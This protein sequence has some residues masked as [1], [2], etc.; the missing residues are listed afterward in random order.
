MQFYFKLPSAIAFKKFLVYFLFFGNILFV[1]YIWLLNS[2]YYITT[3]APGNLYTAIGRITGLWAEIFLLTELILVGRVRWFE[4]LFGF[5]RLNM[6]HR[7]IG[8]GL[9]SL[10]LAHPFFLILGYSQAN[11]VSFLSQFYDF[12]ANK[13]YV[14]YSFMAL[15]IFIYIVFLAVFARKKVHYEVWYFTHLLTY[16]AVGLALWH[17]LGTGDLIGGWTLNYW[18]ILNFSVFGIILAYRFA[19][20]LIRS[21]YHGFTI[22][23][24]IMETPDVTSLYITG[25]HMERFKFQAGQYCNLNILSRGMWYTHPFSL[26]AAYNGQFIRFSIKSCGDYTNKIPTVQPGTKVLVDGPLGLFVEERA[27]RDKYLFVVGGIGIT[28][29]RAMMESL[30]SKG[31]DIVLVYAA[32]TVNDLVF[33]KEIEQIQQADPL[34]RVYYILSAPTPGYESGYLDKEKIVRLIPDFFDRDVFL[35]GP[36]PM[37]KAVVKTLSELGFGKDHIH[38]EKFSF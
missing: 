27:L 22:Q 36:P 35:C 12:L 9:L 21:L 25:R 3:P 20:P 24:V 4:H 10:L 11:S 29:L 7:W 19:R 23:N 17:Q 37:M 18:Y 31:K 34:V 26:S 6:V 8:Y 2:S 28:P 38:F 32:R 13:A 33:R 15:L 1:T 30:A 5:D 14:L 16:L